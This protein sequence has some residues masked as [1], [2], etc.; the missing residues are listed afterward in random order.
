M[1]KCLL[2]INTHTHMQKKIQTNKEKLKNARTEGVKVQF[3]SE[4]C[5]QLLKRMINQW[6]FHTCPLIG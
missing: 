4:A 1:S 3:S 5:R 2:K 6:I